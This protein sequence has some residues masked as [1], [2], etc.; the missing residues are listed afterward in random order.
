MTDNHPPGLY[1]VNSTGEMTPLDTEGDD[2]DRALLAEQLDELDDPR[3]VQDIL[4]HAN[5]DFQ[6]TDLVGMTLRGPVGYHALYSWDS[7]DL[8][9]PLEV[10]LHIALDEV[11][12]EIWVEDDIVEHNQGDV[13]PETVAQEYANQIEQMTG[14]R[15]DAWA[16]EMFR[17]ELSS[18]LRKL[19]N[20]EPSTEA[21]A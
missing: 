9:T 18:A 19:A 2:D 10:A 16:D 8:T 11:L 1:H 5:E 17:D 20:Y 4:K 14:I 3:V 15:M 7:D 12:E 21:E 13:T 6:Q